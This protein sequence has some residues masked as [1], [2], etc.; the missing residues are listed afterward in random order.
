[1]KKE[2]KVFKRVFLIGLAVLICVSGLFFARQVMA[3]TFQGQSE[4]VDLEVIN[5]IEGHGVTVETA[6]GNAWANEMVILRGVRGTEDYDVANIEYVKSAVEGTQGIGIWRDATTYI[7]PST[8]TN[9]VILD[10]GSVGI[11]T[12]TVGAKLHIEGGTPSIF[13]DNTAETLAEFRFR[14]SQGTSSQYFTLGFNS[15]DEKF[16]M[17]PDADT[18]VFVI[19]NAGKI[20]IKET[21]PSDELTVAGTIGT[22]LLEIS[23]YGY[24]LG[25]FHVGDIGDPETDN[26]IVDGKVAI[27][28][29]S[30]TAK[31][32]V[33]GGHLNVS[34]STFQNP[35]GW[36]ST[37]YLDNASHSRILINERSTGTQASLWAHT[38]GNAKVGTVSGHN[39]D[40]MTGGSAKISI[41]H[42]T[43][44]VGIGATVPS[45][46]LHVIG[47]IIASGGDIYMVHD[48]ATNANN[49]YIKYDDGANLGSGGTFHF[50]ADSAR[51]AAW[52]SPTAAISAK[53]GY[54][55]GSVG[56]GASSPGA[57]LDVVGTIQTTDLVAE[58]T[59]TASIGQFNNIVY[60]GDGEV[61]DGLDVDGDATVTGDVGIGTAVPQA[62]L[63]VWDGQAMTSNN[64][65]GYLVPTADQHLTPKKYV[66]DAVTLGG[67]DGYIGDV[68][69]HDA[70]G[71]LNM[72][73]NL[74]TN[75]GNAGTDFTSGGG[76][77]LT[78]QTYTLH[79]SV[80]TFENV[81]HYY[82]GSTPNTGT[83]VVTIGSTPNIMLEA[84]IVVQGYGGLTKCQIRGYTYTGSTSWHE[85]AGTCLSSGHSGGYTIRFGK[86]TSDNARV[87]L[88][89]I[90]SSAWGSYPHV[91][92]TR[93]TYG[94]G[95][96]SSIGEWSISM[97]TDESAY[98]NIVDINENSGFNADLLDN[99]SSGSFL[100]SDTSDY[101]TSGNLYLGTT[102]TYSV[103]SDGDG[104]FRYV[105]IGG[106]NPSATYPLYVNGN[107]YLTGTTYLGT[108]SYY[109]DTSGNANFLS[110]NVTGKLTAGEIDPPYSIDGV[111]YAT[112]GHSTTGLKEETTGK[113]KLVNQVLGYTGNQDLYYYIIDFDEAEKESDLWLF[114]E[115]TAFG[116]DWNDLVVSLTPEGK[117]DVW[118]EFIT[119]ENK[120]IIYGNQLVKV[121]YRLMAPRFDWP[122]RDTNLY[123]QT[124][125]APKG[126]GVFVR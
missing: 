116:K 25:G 65:G 58:D 38:G 43:G 33:R 22:N 89:G 73:N 66:D 95:S 70:G 44:N 94:Y 69:S 75:I 9:F 26:L 99:V 74:I 20:G 101:L 55:F 57:D 68:A 54:F 27:G 40:I 23:D 2:K 125:E 48:G 97:V 115:I 119:E 82:N 102:T 45:E 17:G 105:G 113:V 72:N 67:A 52:N 11:G 41:I 84:E 62:K 122:E 13:L 60:V 61:G 19:D 21:V 47:D 15:G 5:F 39:F 114:K 83:I 111:I 16:Y 49:E 91:A 78:D 12:S 77:N 42:S 29:T 88:L 100:R 59:V 10:S 121:S 107:A 109:V 34:D 106:V 118:Y 126:V 76:L 3:L 31:L 123:N 96:G 120:L 8:Y 64:T 63:H 28:T 51:D 53:G 35:G 24:A 50:H 36:G 37:I 71:A 7:Y 92:V 117:A 112:Y 18:D 46:K 4:Y 104:D 103:Q 86:R 56:I 1:M 80:R 79:D 30:P 85:P 93:V 14:D 32:D 124:G 110:L 6:A 90:T 81:A 87:I 98:S 108:S